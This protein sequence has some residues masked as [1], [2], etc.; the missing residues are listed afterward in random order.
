MQEATEEEVGG[1]VEDIEEGTPDEVKELLTS[2]ESLLSKSDDVDDDDDGRLEG[3][4]MAD[5]GAEDT[6]S[7]WVAFF[8][9]CSYT[10]SLHTQGVKR[11]RKR[12]FSRRMQGVGTQA[13]W[14][15]WTFYQSPEVKKRKITIAAALALFVLG[16]IFFGIGMCL[17]LSPPLPLSL[18]SL[19]PLPFSFL[20]RP[21]A[22]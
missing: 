13:A 21:T 20:Y 2:Q 7:E 10:L 9:L 8:F 5:A 3:E 11:S 1:L 12:R 4:K 17:L 6:P 15:L 19:P 22:G 16:L 18:S 14:T